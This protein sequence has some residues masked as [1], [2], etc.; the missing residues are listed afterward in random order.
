MVYEFDNG[1][2]VTVCRT[3]SFDMWAVYVRNQNGSMVDKDVIFKA[4]LEDL[5]KE[6]ESHG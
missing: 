6:I 5:L 4:D 1:W 3:Y 2:K